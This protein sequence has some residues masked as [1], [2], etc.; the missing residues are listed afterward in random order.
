M[1]D[2]A[3]EELSEQFALWM[4]FGLPITAFMVCI[5]GLITYIKERRKS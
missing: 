3:L 2:K 5:L 1:L 4:I